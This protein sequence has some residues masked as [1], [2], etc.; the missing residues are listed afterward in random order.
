MKW[1]C[2]L[3]PRAAFLFFAVIVLKYSSISFLKTRK[4]GLSLENVY[5]RILNLARSIIKLIRKYSFSAD[6]FI[7]KKPK[8]TFS[9]W[10]WKLQMILCTINSQ[11]SCHSLRV[12]THFQNRWITVSVWESQKAQFKSTSYLNLTKNDLTG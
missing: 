7:F 12:C 5:L 6:M 10:N 11:I 8:S 9:R 2:S 4:W 3:I 1:E